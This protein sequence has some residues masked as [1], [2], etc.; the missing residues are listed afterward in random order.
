MQCAGYRS[1]QRRRIG[2]DW[3]KKEI[4]QVTEES[5]EFMPIIYITQEKRDGYIMNEY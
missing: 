3:Q 1:Y 5:G 2:Q 4:L